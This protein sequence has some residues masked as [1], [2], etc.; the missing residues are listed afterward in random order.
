M[1]GMGSALAF[2]TALRILVAD[3]DAD[4]RE[5]VVELLTDAGAEVASV[6][7]GAELLA[8]LGEGEPYDLVIADL[9]MPWITGLQVASSVRDAGL[10]VP[11]LLI[12]GAGDA[13][14]EERVDSLERTLL[15]RKPFDSEQL[16]AAILEL[17]PGAL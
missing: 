8:R 14:L 3:D 6:Q 9:L 17:L 12:T 4:L 11:V 10:S 2:P 5:S 7:S 15:L 16:R 1:A 13:S